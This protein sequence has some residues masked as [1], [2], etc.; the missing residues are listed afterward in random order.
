MA[1]TQISA[2]ISDETKALMERYVDAH[3]VKKNHLVEEALLHH[4]QALHELPTD[5]VIPP[6]IVLTNESFDQISEL[7]RQPRIPTQAM[8]DLMSDKRRP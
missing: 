2:F 1:A 5:L 7:V 6:R 3:G 4:L 8:R